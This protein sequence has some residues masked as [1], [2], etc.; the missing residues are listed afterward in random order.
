M[1]SADRND[2]GKQWGSQSNKAHG[3]DL[4]TKFKFFEL[5]EDVPKAEIFKRTIGFLALKYKFLTFYRYANLFH[6]KSEKNYHKLIYT[7]NNEINF[8]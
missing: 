1:R 6:K 8:A 2:H 4:H 3:K 5:N 7:D